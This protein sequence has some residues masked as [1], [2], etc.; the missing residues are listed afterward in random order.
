MEIPILEK[1]EGPTKKVVMQ[2]YGGDLLSI[3]NVYRPLAIIL[4]LGENKINAHEELL[5]LIK[6]YD[7]NIPIVW[8][9]P[10]NSKISTGRYASIKKALKN[11]QNCMLVQSDSIVDKLKLT[12]E[13]FYG[14]DAKKL[15]KAIYKQF[16]VFL[17]NAICHD[18][19]NILDVM[20]FYLPDF[21]EAKKAKEVTPLGTSN[22]QRINATIKCMVK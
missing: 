15:A 12:P 18:N 6:S 3:M 9:G 2:L 13:H 7:V 16:E 8:I 21:I 22:K 11:Q 1:A 5:R 20:L 14:N 17:D 19:K 10:F 4:V